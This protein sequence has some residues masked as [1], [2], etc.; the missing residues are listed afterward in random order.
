MERANRAELIRALYR[1]KVG[2][3][4]YRHS[5]KTP[6]PKERAS[7]VGFG[8]LGLRGPSAKLRVPKATSGIFD[9]VPVK[10][11]LRPARRKATPALTHIA[12][13]LPRKLPRVL[14]DL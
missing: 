1:A 4:A 10:E 6:R 7:K 5:G 13:Q 9:P 14:F 2:G 3:L 8:V 12:A 11:P